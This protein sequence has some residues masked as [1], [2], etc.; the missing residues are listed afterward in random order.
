MGLLRLIDWRIAA[1]LVAVIG[2]AGGGYYWIY[3]QGAGAVELKSR[4][5]QLEQLKEAGNAGADNQ[6]RILKEQQE[7]AD[8]ERKHFK[9]DW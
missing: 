1:A 4:A 6:A 2:F 8:G 9:T 7:A 3:Q 5:L